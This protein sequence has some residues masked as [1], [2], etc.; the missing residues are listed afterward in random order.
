MSLNP[1][2][3]HPPPQCSGFEGAAEQGPR[4]SDRQDGPSLP[5]QRLPWPRHTDQA[6]APR[7][8]PG[9]LTRPFTRRCHLAHHHPPPSPPS[10][11]PR[12]CSCAGSHRTG[13]WEPRSALQ[14]A[15][16]LGGHRKEVTAAGAH[17]EQRRDS[18]RK[19]GGDGAGQA[20]KGKL[21]AGPL[22]DWVRVGRTRCCRARRRH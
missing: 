9:R 5:P 16:R 6:L 13:R 4:H 14:E 22:G 12:A 11:T 10:S 21:K 19:R 2:S 17:V 3:A 7:C 8:S 18:S 20:L 15:C 1:P